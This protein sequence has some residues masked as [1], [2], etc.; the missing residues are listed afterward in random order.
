VTTVGQVQG[1]RPGGGRMLVVIA[2][3]AAVAAAAVVVVSL[4]GDTAPL[5]AA[6]LAVGKA[7]NLEIK[8]DPP[9]ALVLIDGA[10]TGLSTPAV[11]RNLRPGS[12]LEVRLD[13]P[14]YHAAVQKIIVGSE[15]A[16]S[17][18]VKLAPASAKVTL[19]GLPAD[20]EVYVDDVLTKPVSGV[21]TVM[22][23]KRKLRVE[24]GGEVVFQKVITAEAAEQSVRIQP[25]AKEP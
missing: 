16:Q 7:V 19:E 24:S 8:S 12:T 10:P 14:G 15:P 22:L 9:G 5:P 18:T 11:L 13:H 23:G 1:A 4:R 20:A 17:Q 6:E 25:A 21:V 3:V 2:A